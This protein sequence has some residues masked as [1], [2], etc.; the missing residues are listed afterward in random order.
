MARQVVDLKGL[1]ED[2]R[3]PWTEHSI[4]KLVRSRTNPIPHKRLNGRGK[5]LFD[6]EQVWRWFDRLPGRNQTTTD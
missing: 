6:L 4:R 3:F 2:P 1:A 5:Y